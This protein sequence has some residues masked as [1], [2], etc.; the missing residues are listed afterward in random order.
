MGALTLSDK[1]AG[2]QVVLRW[3]DNRS[4]LSSLRV[5]AVLESRLMGADNSSGRKFSM[6]RRCRLAGEDASRFA[7]EMLVAD[8]FLHRTEYV[9]VSHGAHTLVVA[10]SGG[11]EIF[12]KRRKEIDAI[13]DSVMFMTSSKPAAGPP[14]AP[15]GVK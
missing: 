11:D 3:A 8:R 13:L 10:V 15:S 9:V 14:A 6:P 1:A 5:A 12:D 7:V 4:R 2:I